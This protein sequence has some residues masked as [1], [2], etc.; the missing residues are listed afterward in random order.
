M[1]MYMWALKTY[2]YMYMTAANAVTYVVVV[3][4]PT[5]S[6]SVAIEAAAVERLVTVSDD[7]GVDVTRTAVVRVVG[8]D[9]DLS[10]AA[11]FGKEKAQ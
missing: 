4:T 7:A 2:M 3:A 11:V 8:A 6:R 5:G 10:G 1:Y 9:V